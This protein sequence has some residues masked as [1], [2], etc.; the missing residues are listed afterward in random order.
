MHP[1]FSSHLS[2]GAAL[3]PTR[4]HWGQR[5]QK[6]ILQQLLFPD[7]RK[8]GPLSA[9]MLRRTPAGAEGVGVRCIARAHPVFLRWCDRANPVGQ[10]SNYGEHR[11][12]TTSSNAYVSISDDLYKEIT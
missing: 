8:S 10:S 5:Q 1:F 7:L 2:R 3:R 4:N 6:P 12:K 9:S 11:T